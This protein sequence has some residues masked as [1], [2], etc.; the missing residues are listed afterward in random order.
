HCKYQVQILLLLTVLE[1]AAYL[2][3]RQTVA[4]LL[5]LNHQNADF[6]Y[7]VIERDAPENIKEMCRGLRWRV[8]FIGQIMFYNLIVIL[9]LVLSIIGSFVAKITST[10][11]T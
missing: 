5:E 3:Q 10:S 4:T 8:E 6:M 9:F 11:R 2:W 7:W 1:I